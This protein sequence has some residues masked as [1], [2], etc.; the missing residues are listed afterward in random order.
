[1]SLIRGIFVI[2]VAVVENYTNS[3]GIRTKK[4]TPDADYYYRLSGSKVVE[5]AKE[6]ENGTVRY[7]FI[8]DAEGR[9]HELH[10]YSGYNDTTP[11]KY[12]Y[13]LNLQGDVVQLRDTSNAFEPLNNGKWI[14]YQNGLAVSANFPNSITMGHAV[15]YYKKG[16]YR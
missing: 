1:M 7:V 8:Y 11:T 13:V 12:F 3:D 9:P 10:Y 16:W 4:E 5:M 15:S 2:F 14:V 6:N